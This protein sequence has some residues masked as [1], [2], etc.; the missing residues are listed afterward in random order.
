MNGAMEAITEQPSLRGLDQ[1]AHLD[2]PALKQRYVTTMFEIIAPRYDRFT[3]AFSF[4]MDAAWKRD[5]VAMARP[6]VA[7]DASILDL[8]C[9]TGDI[10]FA[11]AR[12]NPRGLVHGVDA[13]PGMVRLARR[14]A[15]R[16]GIAATFSVGDLSALDMPSA[17]QD[18]V[19]IGYG[20]RNVPSLH[21]ALGE[22]HRVLRPGG[23]VANLDF[24]LP[25]AGWWRSLLLRYLLGMGNLYG[26]LWHGDPAV[27]GYIARSIERFVTRPALLAAFIA[28]GFDIVASSSRLGGGVSLHVA[29]KRP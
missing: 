11:L 17:C 14:A 16:L 20:L 23:I 18:V 8:A 19:S 24:T 27:Y 12:W 9:G 5:L 28:N 13:A 25:E 10:A 22:I 29:R 6:H 2:A 21:V 7:V 3:R 26:A 4:G 1:V 15:D